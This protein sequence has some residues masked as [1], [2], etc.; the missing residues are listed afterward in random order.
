[1]YYKIHTLRLSVP[2][3]LQLQYTALPPHAL[4]SFSYSDV[5]PGLPFVL[6]S[7]RLH[8]IDLVPIVLPLSPCHAFLTPE[9]SSPLLPF[10]RREYQ[11][12]SASAVPRA[13]TLDNKPLRVCGSRS[14]ILSAGHSTERGRRRSE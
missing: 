1:M 9:A 5:L 8:H 12:I 7:H 6:T 2:L 13:R 4:H 11:S 14:S 3:R 10:R